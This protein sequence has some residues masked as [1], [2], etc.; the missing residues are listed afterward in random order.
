[1]RLRRLGIALTVFPLI[2]LACWDTAQAQVA[3]LTATTIP[4]GSVVVATTASRNLSITNSGTSNLVITSMAAT[5]SFQSNNCANATI[6]PKGSCTVGLTFTPPTLGSSSGTSTITD[7]ASNT[8]QVVTL[9]GTGVAA[10]TLNPATL[11]FPS[12]AVGTSSAAQTVTLTNNQTIPLNITGVTSTGDFA[13]SSCASPLAAHGS[14]VISVTFAPSTLGSRTGTLT[15]SDDASNSPQTATLNGLG[16][17]P[18][19]LSQTAISFSSQAIN[20]TSSSKTVTLTNNQSIPLNMSSAVVTG[21]FAATRCATPLAAHSSCALGIT[22]TPMAVGTRTGAVTFTDDASNS[23]QTLTLTGTGALTVSLSPTLLQFPSQV[24]GTTSKVQTVTLTNYQST[25]LN[26]SSVTVTGPFTAAACP[27]SLPPSGTCVI[28][29][30]F[31]PTAAGSTSGILTV[32]DSASTSPQ[33]A[34]LQGLGTAV[35]LTSITVAPASPSPALGTTQQLTATGNYNNGTA[36]TLNAANWTSSA[37]NVAIVNTAGLVTTVATGATTITA[38]SG[39][40][41]G[42]TTLTVS[43][44][45]L[46]SI[47]VTPA[48]PAVASGTTQQ[49]T[50]PGT[51]TD[52]STNNLTPSVTWNSSNTAISTLT[53]SGLATGIAVGPATVTATLGSLAG[54]TTLSVTPAVLASITLTPLNPSAPLGATQQFTATG[55]FTDG[56]TQDLTA[57]ATWSSSSPAT[58]T[59]S[60]GGLAQGLGQ[61]TATVSAVYGSV[62]GTDTF[63][64]TAAVLT[65]ITVN[66]SNPSIAL[67]TTQ[68]LTATGTFTDGTTQNLTSTATWSSA[69]TSVAAISA[70]GLASSASTGTTLISATS[71]SVVGSTSLTVTPAGL[72]SIS[73]SPNSAAIGQGTTQQ[74][75]ATGVYTDGTSQDLTTTAYWTS[76]AAGVAT[77]SDASGS[78]GIATGAG[79]GTTIITANAGTI[80]GTANLIVT[81]SAALV[82]ITVGPANLSIP[83]GTPQQFSAIGNYADG[84][85][86]DLSATAVWTSSTATVAPVNSTGFA[87]SASLGST[88]ITATYASISG[89]TLLTVIVAVLNTITVTPANPLAPLGI[90]VQFAATGTFTDGTQQNLTS[91]ATWTSSTTAAIVGS[92]GLA[93]TAALGATVVTATSGAVSGFTTLTVTPA[94]LV[95]VGVTPANASIPLGTTQQLVATGIYTDGS[96]QNL[97]GSVAWISANPAVALVNAAGMAT[98]ITIGSTTITAGV[99]SIVGGASLT[100][101]APALVSIA[102]TPAASTVTLG[103]PVQFTATGTFTDGSTQ[104]VTSTGV[105]WSARGVVGGNSVVG[106]ITS[107]GLYQPPATLPSPP[108]VSITATSTANSNI[109]GGT[110]LSLSQL[111]VSVSPSAPLLQTGATLP[112]TASVTGSSNLGVTWSAGGVA[113]GNSTVGTISASGLYAAPATVPNPPQVTVTATSV[114]DGVTSGSTTLTVILPIMVT[115]SPATQNV[116]VNFSQQYNATVTGG[117]SHSLAWSAGGVAGGNA[118]VGTISASGIY[119]APLLVPQPSLVTIT[120]TGVADSSKS[121]SAVATVIVAPHI[122]VTVSPQT[123][124]VVAGAKLQFQA[125]VWDSSNIN[126]TWSVGGVAGGNATLGTI[127]SGG[128][129]S[130]PSVVPNPAQVVVTA[131]SVADPTKSGN[132]NVTVG[133]GTYSATPLTDFAPGQLYLGQFSGLLYNGSNSP[134]PEQVAAGLAAAASV[135]PLDANGN[136]NPNGKIVLASLGMSNAWDEWCD[137]NTKCTAFSF[138]GQ[139]ASSNAV[140]HAKIAVVDGAYPGETTPSWAC[141]QGV[142]PPGTPNAN[143]YDR[144]RD[145]FL[146]PAGLTEAQVQVVWIKQSN[147]GGYAF[148]SLPSS[149]SDAYSFEYQLGQV[150][151]ALKTRWPNVRQ[152]F[153]SSRIYAGYSNAGVNPEPYAYEYSFSV[154]WLVNAQI[155]Q[156]DTGMADPLAGDLLTAVPWI[157]WGPYI[158]GNGTNN[159]PGSTALTWAPTDYAADGEHPGNTGITKVGTALMNFFLTSPYTPWFRN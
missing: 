7:N 108:Q 9:S 148:P 112:F 119:T 88:T 54:S 106:T 154:K 55:T 42:S 97:T 66:P 85:T 60:S 109:S 3:T 142:C 5:G 46:V 147:P 2:W 110:T 98:S 47:A 10:V 15:V 137:S 28:S 117:L 56:T 25:T 38:A 65:S 69:T 4:F 159:P 130:A 93:S 139:V 49:F 131:T 105:T 94:A 153:I 132:S 81:P 152:V 104:N 12:Q 89:S 91:T 76:S 150:L 6:L 30:A 80:S 20:T 135:Q 19:T 155:V 120:A 35:A 143:N 141:A 158:W 111:A 116:H 140:N 31:V 71:G 145:T 101:S 107:S 70:T 114:V 18:V 22:F 115:V 122:T 11:T 129:Y 24:V 39:G 52:G 149:S 78:Q 96:Q 128:L 16:A 48:N 40:V 32:T 127:S 57:S 8:P 59:L 95:S 75:T 79:A 44:P 138:M 51:Y 21:D 118:I 146:T 62:T 13:A 64:V 33:I 125:S 67:G 124:W 113:G 123:T 58:A 84:S 134:P 26:I 63:T 77:I 102:V 53:A 41:S 61:G 68:Q 87:S 73:V 34:A 82:A 86:L 126:V 100:I 92:S 27:A 36:V 37:T 144:V 83:L 17:Q 14:C 90:S 43:P 29:V 103:V 23:P 121:A 1:M 50:A 45:A 99:S 74:F 136:P 151:R 133:T 156:R 72:T 157:D